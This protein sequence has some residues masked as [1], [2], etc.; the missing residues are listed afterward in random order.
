MLNCN[1]CIIILIVL[2][3]CCQYIA[4]VA[5]LLSKVLQLE[6]SISFHGKLDILAV[7][8]KTQPSKE[9]Y[10]TTEGACKLLAEGTGMRY[11]IRCILYLLKFL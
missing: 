9:N 7:Q 4:L 8:K 6:F 10:K 5:A 2:P 11:A 3:D 1:P